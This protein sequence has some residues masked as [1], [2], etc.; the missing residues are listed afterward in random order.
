[1]IKQDK[2]TGKFLKGHERKDLKSKEKE[3]IELYKSGKS[4]WFIAKKFNCDHSS[5]MYRL[6]R[7]NI[8]IRPQSYYT[9]EKHGHWKGCGSLDG[10]YWGS[11]KQAAK[12]RN[13]TVEIS[14]E[15]AWELFKKQ[16]SR[17][18]LSGTKLDFDRAL[19]NGEYY[20]GNASLDRIDSSKGY[21]KDNI[22]WIDKD[23]NKMKNDLPQDKFLKLCETITKWKQ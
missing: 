16:H 6:K 22:Q 12:V 13:I 11:I 8:T 1:M 3:I 5:I 20:R 14:I 10:R 23:I 2:K 19:G 18:S 15:D 7:A 21:V 4:T 17:C 9:N